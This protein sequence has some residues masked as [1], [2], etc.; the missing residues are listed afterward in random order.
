MDYNALDAA[1]TALG[2]TPPDVLR[3]SLYLDY[4]TA[5]H[6]FFNTTLNGPA[7]A[8][9][10][11]AGY[12]FVR[13][14]VISNSLLNQLAKILDFYVAPAVDADLQWQYQP[15]QGHGPGSLDPWTYRQYFD[16][17]ILGANYNANLQTFRINY[18][19]SAYALG[20]LATN[21]QN[22]IKECCERVFADGALLLNFYNDLYNN[23][24]AI[25][26]LT[27]IK[28]SGSDFH[29]GGKQVLILEF[30]GA[31][32][33]AGA[34]AASAIT[35]KIVYKPSD[36][37]ADCLIAGDSAAVNRVIP[38]FMANSLFEIYNATLAANPAIGGLPLNTYRILPRNYN[39]LHGAGAPLPIRNAYGYIQYLNYDLE[40]GSNE[41]WGFYPGATSDFMVFSSQP[42]S[43]IS[44]FYRRAGAICAL[45]TTFSIFD[46]HLE[47]FRVYQ[48][49]PYPIDLE[50]SL[51]SAANDIQEVS[52]IAAG[53]GA[54]NGV[55][56]DAQDFHWEIMNENTPG[57]A[58]IIREYEVTHYANRLY[59]SLPQ[60]E[61]ELVP[62]DN[63]YLFEGYNEGMQVLRAAQI[64]LNF[65]PWFVR[66]NNNVVVRYL[67]FETPIFKAVISRV[68]LDTLINGNGR[69]AAFQATLDTIMLQQR[70][71]KFDDYV[72]SNPGGLPDFLAFLDIESGP[73]YQNLDIPVFYH[74][75]G[76][77]ST[78]IV[79]SRGVPVAIPGQIQ[80]L[81]G[82]PPGVAAMVN[83]QPPHV[84]RN[85]FFPAQPT[86]AVVRINQVTA[87]GTPATY[88]ARFNL[89]QQSMLTALGLTA[90]PAIPQAVIPDFF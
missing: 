52:L 90:V 80:I 4:L 2:V 47:N 46:L 48:Y 18:P 88:N 6:T 16:N 34:A 59:R 37:E 81:Q 42:E 49:N 14:A 74:C 76:A 67:P 43:I 7:P 24:L 77:G 13:S 33:P 45:A 56:I 27:S 21:F 28:S 20:R 58:S 60:R 85:T 1:L 23:T 68:F 15:A 63:A 5:A 86:N 44:N 36:L 72:N 61:K 19:I 9:L 57:S 10:T 25:H 84:G 78:G 39:S 17:I 30:R 11:N 50:V 38:G 82:P 12:L 75:I 89:I 62:I 64:A 35:F 73:D 32:L 55:S 53:N 31:Y 66:L 29:K 65:D 79:N 87:L 51:T 71:I 26:Q 54:L 22:N 40:W 8:G 41:W 83:C 70:T 69:N 3:A